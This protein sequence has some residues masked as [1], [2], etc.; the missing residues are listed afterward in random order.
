LALAGAAVLLLTGFGAG[1]LVLLI[2][3]GIGCRSALNSCTIAPVLR[4]TV[5]GIG[6]APQIAF[7]EILI[8]QDAMG[9][10]V[11][12]VELSRARGPEQYADGHQAKDQH[13]G[14]QTIDHFHGCLSAL[15]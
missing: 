3:R 9:I 7:I 15:G 12:I 1:V 2:H 4:A 8:H 5:F 13:A 14:D 6:Q 10:A 11:E